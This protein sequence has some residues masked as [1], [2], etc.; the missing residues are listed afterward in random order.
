MITKIDIQEL[1]DDINL[2][3]YENFNVGIEQLQISNELCENI[4]GA[5]NEIVDNINIIL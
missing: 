5:L 3:I 1:K 4:G 2:I